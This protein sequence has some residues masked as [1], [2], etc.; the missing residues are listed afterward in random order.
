MREYSET[1]LQ[2]NTLIKVQACVNFTTIVDCVISVY[3][4]KFFF[5]VSFFYLYTIFISMVL[6]TKIV[7]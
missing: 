3:V 1:C 4:I 6:N 2:N 5:F 7:T